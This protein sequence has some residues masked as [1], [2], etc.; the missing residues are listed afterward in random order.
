MT[1]PSVSTEQPA[2]S[3]ESPAAPPATP[4]TLFGRRYRRRWL[5]VL[6]GL[7][8]I[9]GLLV[10]E[11][12][13]FLS[14]KPQETVWQTITDGVTLDGTVPKQTALEA[15]AYVF[16]VDI[17]G[18]VVPAG[19]EGGDGPTSGSGA[20]RWVLASWDQLTPDQQ[21]VID[22]YLT[23]GPDDQVLEVSPVPTAVP[24]PITEPSTASPSSTSAPSPTPE[25]APTDQP[26]ASAQASA[27]AQGSP[28][29][30][31]ASGSWIPPASPAA[32]VQP[33]F[34]L[35][36]ARNA[37]P[38]G[39]RAQLIVAPGA[40][41]TL[42]QAMMNELLADIA[43]IG[44]KLNMAVIGS[45]FPLP[46]I[47][48]ALSGQSGGD[49]LLVTVAR[50]KYVTFAGHPV[51]G[52]WFTPCNVTAFKES[53]Q[54]E[55]VTSGGGVSP[56]LHVLITHEVVHCYQNV[57]WGSEAT[58]TAMPSWLVEGTAMFLAADDT[59]IAEP[60]LPNVWTKGYIGRL[61]HALTSRT[62]DSFGYYA[63][64]KHLG[65][66]LWSLM[67]P[68]WQAAA[69]R[70]SPSNDFI[71]VLH[72]DDPDVRDAWAEN[73]LR[74]PAWGDPWIMYGF[75]LPD[76][77][78]V[79]D[80]PV[81]AQPDPGWIGSLPSRANAVLDV[82]S[83]SGEVVTVATDGL[84]SVHDQSGNSALAFQTQTF[85]TAD[86]GCV[87][88]PD[89]ALAGQDM[90][91]KKLT[92]PFDVAFNSPLGGSKYSIIAAKL[93]D[94]CHKRATPQPTSKNPCGTACPGSN[95][96]P[97]MLTVN[98][99]R[100][101]F[102]AAGE[103]TLLNSADGSLAIQA[104]QEPFGTAGHV[105]INTAIAAEVGSH[106]VGVYV[107]GPGLQARVDGTVVDLTAGPKDLGDGAQLTAISK[108]FEIDFADGT[109]LWAL[110]VGEY[111]INVQ[112]KP[113]DSLKTSGVGLL[114][115]IVKGGLGVPALPD[116]TRLPAAT[117]NPQR[118]GIV[119]GQFADA[120]RVTDS[121][122]LFDYDTGKSTATYTIRPYPL[123]TKYGGVGDLSADQQAAG[124]SACSSI[125]DQGLHDDCVFDVGVTGQTGFA[126]GYRDI[127]TF[128]DSGIAQ[129]TPPPASSSATPPPA[130]AV[131][132]A[133]TVAQNASLGGYA[134]GAND[135]VYVSVQTGDTTFSLMA[136]DPVAQKIV[137]QV[138]VPA[139]TQV[140]YAA[141][142][143]WLPGLKTDANGHNCSITRF[144][145]QT[146][147]EQATIQVPCSPGGSVGLVASDGDAVWYEDDSKY[148]LTTNSGTVLARID[149]ATNA[150]GTSV[151]LPFEGGYALD[152]QGAFFYYD[153]GSG[154]GYYRLTTG[155]TTFDSLGAIVGTAR[156]G[157]TGLWTSSSDHKTAQ[158]FTQ[159][160]A[161]AATLQ[162]DGSVVAGDENA[163][164]VETQGTDPSGNFAEQLWRY[165][166]DG[167]TPAQIA[168]APA[169][170]GNPLS[171]F[172][173]PLP[174][175]NGDGVV[176]LWMARTGTDQTNTL[177]LQWVPVQ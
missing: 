117:S 9:G 54:G 68:A 157:G 135:T 174:I 75:G 145:G 69:K 45:G 110:S 74:Q 112:I 14:S 143:V 131:S 42:A 88:P 65:R 167:S 76:A 5:A 24:S 25:P 13:Q 129:A 127:Q 177:L 52:P 106:R 77:A 105:S 113:S 7:L 150:P 91:S 152:S 163:A 140:H 159:A 136:V 124:N 165:P 35:L 22:R 81:Q 18:V 158:Y 43:H 141:G 101:D 53:W 55:S 171:Y 119:N 66:N 170:D 154:K 142:S 168:L 21:A 160:G 70:V 57:I 118:N 133:M 46:N 33:A 34:R 132:G 62:Y 36:S 134:I 27:P 151:P 104:R 173:D 44:P 32:L 97:H 114:G 122:T 82:T 67:L 103:F 121:T 11:V 96:D 144:D 48:L 49:A 15:F 100:Y 89:T 28:I 95:G 85:C 109:K 92:L 59:G 50:D 39:S 149:P 139:L 99:Y 172:D 123:Y 125:T 86:G 3:T 80:V 1:E 19:V 61:D 40:P 169:I 20:M 29:A 120:W 126:T 10:L 41:L 116:G 130:G 6:L 111:G 38:G 98:L 71:A 155:S 175:S 2:S 102:Q 47:T 164:Y 17:P 115:P 79:Q 156:P 107:N 8:V 37:Q 23:P 87:C 58:A 60:T 138:A 64:L 83:S 72:G 108:G 90:A 16:K 137:N 4:T 128:Y 146:L 30:P 12:P 153:T 161:P 73:Y 51:S 63:L 147:A 94:L 176:K 31:T 26:S 162:I 148:D 166:A 93:D 56:R 78:V 84:A